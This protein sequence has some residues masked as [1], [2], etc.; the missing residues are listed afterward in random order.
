[1]RIVGGQ[2]KGRRL[3]R[4]KGN[5]L[6]PTSERV[7]EA[8][9]SFMADFLPCARFLDLYAGTGA[10]G[11]EALSRGAQQVVFVESQPS[12]L[13][14]IRDNLRRCGITQQARIVPGEAL[15][16]LRKWTRSCPFDS[17]DII[18][19]DP[20]YYLRVLE[21]L[22]SLLSQSPLLHEKS[23]VIIEHARQQQL[24]PQLGRLT[25]AHSYHYGDTT[26]TRFH[27]LADN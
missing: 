7:R 19:A 6:R 17:F 14:V 26:L 20:P 13:Q 1:M 10:V 3:I 16:S 9:F 23:Q 12:S 22:I 4:P 5:H 8:L 18:F 27:V 25:L 11:I 15:A 2:L 21:K 24:P